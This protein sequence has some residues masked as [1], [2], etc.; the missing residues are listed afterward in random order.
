MGDFK[1]YLGGSIKWLQ[2]EAIEY[3]IVELIEQKHTIIAGFFLNDSN[4]SNYFYTNLVKYLAF[5][6]CYKYQLFFHLFVVNNY[7]HFT[8]WV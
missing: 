6:V 5:K 8:E 1:A 4:L 2:K 3:V 7:L